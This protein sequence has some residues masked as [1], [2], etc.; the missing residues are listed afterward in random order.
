MRYLHIQ[1]QKLENQLEGMRSRVQEMAKDGEITGQVAYY[2]EHGEWAKEATEQ[3]SQE[4]IPEVHRFIQELLKNLELTELGK[5]VNS[6]LQ[7]NQGNTS[8]DTDFSHMMIHRMSV[9][10]FIQKWGN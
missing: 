5:K 7:R 6:I 1:I 4:E 2:L 8:M 10:S 3:G 9:E